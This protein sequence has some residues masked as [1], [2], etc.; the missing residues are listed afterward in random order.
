MQRGLTG[1]FLP[2]PSPGEKCRAFVPHPLP[3]EPALLLDVTLQQRLE[4]A[5]LAL[6]RLDGNGRVGRLLIALLLHSGGALREPLLYLSLYFK[7]HRNRY[8]ELLPHVR[9]TGDWEAWL[10]FFFSGVEQ[11]DSQAAATAH[12]LLKLASA[13]EVRIQTLGRAFG[14]VA[15][16]INRLFSTGNHTRLR[17]LAG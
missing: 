1:Y 7:Q 8:Y 12:D 9:L 11:T 3:P 17:V 5:T 6:G 13:D 14:C 10:D 2:I 4:R 15:S 16:T